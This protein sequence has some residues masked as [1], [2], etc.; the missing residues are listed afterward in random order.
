MQTEYCIDTTCRVAFELGFKVI[1]PE[2]TNTTFDNGDI[3][4]SQ[5]CEYHNRRI[6]ADR[7]A[8]VCSM[9]VALAKIQ[10]AVA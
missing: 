6:F 3:P 10:E 2:W 4:A 7:F 1:M 8:E 9:D 5:I